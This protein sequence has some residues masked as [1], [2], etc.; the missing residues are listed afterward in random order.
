MEMYH[1]GTGFCY[2]T[3]GCVVC[4]STSDFE[5]RKEGGGRRQKEGGVRSAWCRRR[6]RRRR[7]ERNISQA[8]EKASFLK[9]HLLF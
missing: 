3:Q 9:D 1:L 4:T 6:V 5:G 7:E 8:A 2:V